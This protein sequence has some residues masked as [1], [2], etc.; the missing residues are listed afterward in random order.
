MTTNRPLTLRVDSYSDPE[1]ISGWICDERGDEQHF[2]GWLGLF[3][4]L[5][6]TLWQPTDAGTARVGWERDVVQPATSKG[7]RWITASA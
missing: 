2:E 4:L 3:T 5:E 6:Q 7:T 1:R